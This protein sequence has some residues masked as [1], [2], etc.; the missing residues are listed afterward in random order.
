M[1]R[2]V[3][4]CTYSEAHV[5]IGQGPLSSLSVLALLV[6]TVPSHHDRGDDG[7]FEVVCDRGVIPGGYLARVQVSIVL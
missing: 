7:D 6:V 2:S 4:H 1:A 5:R 3:W